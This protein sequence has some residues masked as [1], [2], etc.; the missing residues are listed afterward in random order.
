M[1][2]KNLFALVKNNKTPCNSNSH[3]ALLLGT[4]TETME[5][6]ICSRDKLKE[7]LAVE[8]YSFKSDEQDMLAACSDKKQQN[9]RTTKNNAVAS[10]ALHTAFCMFPRK[11]IISSDED[12]LLHQAQILSEK[13]SRVLLDSQPDMEQN[14]IKHELNSSSFVIDQTYEFGPYES[15][16]PSLYINNV[17]NKADKLL[18]H[19][20]RQTELAGT[21]YINNMQLKPFNR[22]GYCN[23]L[24]FVCHEPGKC[25]F[26][27]LYDLIEDLKRRIIHIDKNSFSKSNTQLLQSYLQPVEELQAQLPNLIKKNGCDILF[28]YGDHTEHYVISP[29]AWNSSLYETMNSPRTYF[30]DI[31]SQPLK[32][33]SAIRDNNFA[34][35][36]Q[37][38]QAFNQENG[39]LF[40]RK[41]SHTTI[42]VRTPETQPASSN[43]FLWILS[44][45]TILLGFFTLIC[46]IILS[47]LLLALGLVLK[48]WFDLFTRRLIV[49]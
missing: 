15:S 3:Y 12:P 32:A 40:S 30:Y 17:P 9:W 25:N 24:A 4:S 21:N 38:S 39:T 34:Y 2:E 41:Q 33:W 26:F 20:L 19:R 6:V 35:Y 37:A 36:N 47:I 29:A 42:K 13:L 8:N 43:V 11:C 5:L 45:L 18:E 10:C 27:T 22:D 1:Q 7:F 16:H 28:L 48:F 14:F 46:V 23:P 49:G 31:L 44:F